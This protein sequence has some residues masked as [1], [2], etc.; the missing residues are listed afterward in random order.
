M[1]ASLCRKIFQLQYARRCDI[2]KLLE[3]IWCNQPLPPC[4]VAAR[5]GLCCQAK[6]RK[7]VAAQAAATRPRGALGVALRPILFAQL[8]QGAVLLADA[9]VLQRVLHA[10]AKLGNILA[11]QLCALGLFL[12]GLLPLAAEARKLVDAFD[13]VLF[14]GAPFTVG[15]DFCDG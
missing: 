14:H 10:L 1:T 15:R 3:S 9:H 5:E 13:L 4:P 8:G 6:G 7:T 2:I 12:G 11:A